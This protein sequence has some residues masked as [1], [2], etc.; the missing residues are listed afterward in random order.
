MWAVDMRPMFIHHQKDNDDGTCWGWNG[1][2][3]W[4]GLNW[5]GL[6]KREH[7]KLLWVSLRDVRGKVSSAV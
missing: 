7:L 5:T 1:Q 6:D 3:G 2:R 4:T